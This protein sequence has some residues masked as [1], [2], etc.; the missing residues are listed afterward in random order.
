MSFLLTRAPA[1]RALRPTSHGVHSSCQETEYPKD[2]RDPP[3]LPSQPT[4][5]LSQCASPDQPNECRDNSYTSCKITFPSPTLPLIHGSFSHLGPV[6]SIMASGSS[7]WPCALTLPSRWYRFIFS[8]APGCHG[9]CPPSSLSVRP[10][11]RRV[12]V[13]PVIIVI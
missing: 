4:L 6:T 12:W 2:P 1:D 5:P 9:S 13:P 3:R 10:G 8:A 11:A 7:L